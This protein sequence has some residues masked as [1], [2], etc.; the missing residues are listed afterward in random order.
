MGAKDSVVLVAPEMLV[1]PV[2]VFCSHWTAGVGDPEATAVKI[3]VFLY[4]RVWLDGCVV[5]TGAGSVSVTDEL[6]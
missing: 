2:P 6:L 1:H 4:V 3:A 5:M